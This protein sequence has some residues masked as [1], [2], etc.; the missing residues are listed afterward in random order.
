MLQN[1]G[2]GHFVAPAERCA[3]TNLCCQQHGVFTD[4]T[5]TAGLTSQN[6]GF[7]GTFGYYNNDSF[8]DLYVSFSGKNNVLY[9]NNGHGVFTDAT[10]T[11]GVAG[12]GDMGRGTSWGD[13]NNDGLLDLAMVSADPGANRMYQNNG[14]GTFKDITSSAGISGDID[15]VAQVRELP[16]F[17]RPSPHHRICRGHLHIL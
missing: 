17:A 4:V 16:C 11:A 13:L 3:S 15:G 5:S 6:S 12:N 14:D 2:V 10:S 8:L 7:E 9:V 1:N